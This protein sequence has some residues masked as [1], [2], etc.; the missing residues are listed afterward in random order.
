MFKQLLLN[1]NP[2]TFFNSTRS[3]CMYMSAKTANHKNLRY[4]SLLCW[5]GSIFNKRKIQNFY[6][7]SKKYINKY[8]IINKL[9]CYHSKMNA[10]VAEKDVKNIYSTRKH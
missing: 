4:F 6:E 3:C 1:D 9:I 8:T 5:N 2:Q 7:I 10:K